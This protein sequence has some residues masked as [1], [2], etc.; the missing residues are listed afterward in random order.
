M[1]KVRNSH[2]ASHHSGVSCRSLREHISP[3]LQ[4]PP[5]PVLSMLLVAVA[6]S[7]SGGI[8]LRYTSGFMDDVMFS[9]KGQE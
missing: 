2:W 1:Q 6:R 7:S 4:V 8:A 9:H 5:L 3:E